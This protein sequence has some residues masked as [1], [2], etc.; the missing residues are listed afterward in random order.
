ATAGISGTVELATTNRITAVAASAVQ[1]R[2]GSN[3]TTLANYSGAPFGSTGAT[4][5]SIVF[6]SGSTYTHNNG[7]NPFQ[8][9]APSSVVVY[10][11][12]S[13][14]VWNTSSGFD[15]TGRTYGNLT[16][17]APISVANTGA[18]TFGL[19]TISAAGQF[20]LTGAGIT[21]VNIRGGITNNSANPISIGCGSGNIN[22]QNVTTQQLNGTGTGNITFVTVNGGKAVINTSVNVNTNKNVTLTDLVNNGFVT[23]TAPATW[24]FAGTLSGSGS[25]NSSGNYFANLDFQ[26][27]SVSF[28]SFKTTANAVN[29]LTYNRTGITSTFTSQ[30]QVWGIVDVQAG[31]L[32][33]NGFLRL[34]SNSARQGIIKAS[35]GTITGNVIVDRFIPGSGAGNSPARML[36]SA[37]SGLTTN[38]AWSDDFPVVGDYPYTYCSTCPAATVYPTIWGY[39][40][41]NV[42]PQSQYESANTVTIN[43]MMGF[44]SNLQTL[45]ARQTDVVG[46]VN[47]GPLSLSLPSTLNGIHFVGNPY[48]SPIRWSLVR[49]LPGQ[50]PLQAA[51]YGWSATNNN[52][53]NFNGTV[54]TFGLNDTIYLG[55]GFSV[56]TS[57]P[58][59]G[60]FIMNNTV[61]HLSNQSTFYRTESP[62]RVLKMNIEGFNGK[63]QFAV[64]TIEGGKEA[65]NPEKDVKKISANPVDR[66]PLISVV[67]ENVSLAIKELSDEEI[68]REIP[69]K[70]A[71]KEA[72]VYT[73][74]TAEFTNFN[75]VR[76]IFTDKLLGK[77]IE[78]NESFSYQV[79]LPEGPVENRFFLNMGVV[80]MVGTIESNG[81]DCF[82]AEGML[83]IFNNT[84]E[85]FGG[86]VQLFDLSGKLLFNQNVNL[87]PGQTSVQVPE[88]SAGVYIANIS[89]AKEPVTRK[90]F[91]K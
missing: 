28:G 1:F 67:V 71:T 26:P 25:F 87:T 82:G 47:D 19:M 90:V 49:N 32:A 59:G 88:V 11:A 53:G 24:S 33:S 60:N 79:E 40:D 56:T 63:D 21:A 73:F 36:S 70:V 64:Y 45:F 46:P 72:G 29:N 75:G 68:Q 55:Q 89:G 54:G 44:F 76:I 85:S 34:G 2:T 51:Y 31:T 22:F 10:Q 80:D 91:I 35:A 83:H 39:D 77:N 43:P 6:Q 12:G 14:Q 66:N 69:I 30:V 42:A 9:T 18:F 8:R 37:V 27:A 17:G 62:N 65:Y 16:I 48:P 61:R 5:N 3:C 20:T 13:N 4:A 57:T 58:A 81:F 23:F 50:V 41:N 84:K 38:T 78:V 86:S 74:N 7:D 52:W 15:V